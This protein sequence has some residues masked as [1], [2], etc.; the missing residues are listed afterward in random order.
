MTRTDGKLR[1]VLRGDLDGETGTGPRE[2]RE[3]GGA[4][5]MFMADSTNTVKQ[6]SSN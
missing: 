6:L 2:A 3:G 5:R 1:P 4:M